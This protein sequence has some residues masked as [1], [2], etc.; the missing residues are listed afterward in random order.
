MSK[1]N[2]NPELTPFKN[3]GKIDANGVFV[4]KKEHLD[5]ISFNKD[6]LSCVY[7]PGPRVFY[8]RPDGKTFEAHYFDNGCD[9]FNEGLARGIANGKMVFFNRKLEIKIDTPYDTIFPFADGYAVVC[10][11]CNKVKIGEHTGFRGGKCGYIDHSGKVIVPL[12]YT[13]ENLPPIKQTI[14]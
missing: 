10:N 14:R 3:C 5:N 11:D 1:D 12:E 13:I 4:L 6:N 8:V 9:Y 2:P 7:T